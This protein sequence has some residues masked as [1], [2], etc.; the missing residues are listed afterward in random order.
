MRKSGRWMITSTQGVGNKVST[1]QWVYPPSQESRGTII[2]AS[3]RL[4][5]PH[6]RFAGAPTLTAET[7]KFVIVKDRVAST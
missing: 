6:E 7:Y 4:W 3:F 2:V 1:I 5:S